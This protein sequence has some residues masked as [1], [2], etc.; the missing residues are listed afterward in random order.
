VKKSEMDGNYRMIELVFSNLSQ[1]T[2]AGKS[3]FVLFHHVHL[4]AIMIILLI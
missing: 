1:S 3:A 2:N 4:C